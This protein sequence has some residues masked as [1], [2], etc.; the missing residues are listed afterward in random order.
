MWCHCSVG[1]LRRFPPDMMAAWDDQYKRTTMEGE[2]F[3]FAM[4]LF[5][6]TKLTCISV[7]YEGIGGRIFTN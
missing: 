6:E 2:M 3:S 7:H 4:K 1:E 5:C